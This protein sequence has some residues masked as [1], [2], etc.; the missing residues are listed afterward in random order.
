[1]GSQWAS[2]EENTGKGVAGRSRNTN[3]AR[4]RSAGARLPQANARSTSVLVDEYDA[5]R[6]SKAL[7]T[8][9]LLAAVM[10]VWL[11]APSS[12]PNRGETQ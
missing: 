2:T 9:K 8:A 12:T 11:S 7:R 3:A 1:M 10:E 5:G 6:Y 4:L